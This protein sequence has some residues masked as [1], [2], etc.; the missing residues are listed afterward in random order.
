MD[1]SLEQRLLRM[2]WR[3][4]EGEARSQN[5]LRALPAE[6][7]ALEGECIDGAVFRECADL[8][9]YEFDAPEN[10]SKFRAGDAVVVGDGVDFDGGVQMSFARYDG[11]RHVLVLQRDPFAKGQKY[12]FEVGGRYCV[13]R[14]S[15]GLRGRLHEVV[16]E[17]FADARIAAVLDGTHEMRFEAGRFERARK[18]LAERGLNDAR[19]SVAIAAESLAMIQGPPGTGKTR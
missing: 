19:L 5:D 10:M 2:L 16:R 17:G 12:E 9:G 1:R 13:D 14:R 4:E 3:E 7:R 11:D 18:T 15:L 8:D 6:D